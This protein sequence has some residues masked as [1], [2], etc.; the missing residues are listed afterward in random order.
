MLDYVVRFKKTVI[1]KV[2]VLAHYLF[3]KDI[4]CSLLSFG[5]YFLDYISQTNKISAFIYLF[6]FNTNKN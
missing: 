5:Y 6:I 2:D 1:I 4:I 3:Q